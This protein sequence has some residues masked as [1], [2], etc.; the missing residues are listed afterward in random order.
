MKLRAVIPLS[1]GIV[2]VRDTPCIYR[3]S[4][5]YNDGAEPLTLRRARGGLTHTLTKAVLS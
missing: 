5:T 4:Y 2:S 3:Q 1:N